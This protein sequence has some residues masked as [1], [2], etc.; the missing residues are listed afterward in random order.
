MKG[1]CIVVEGMT[2]EDRR[3]VS[4]AFY[5]L[6][7]EIYIDI[8]SFPMS[9]KVF[10][11][12]IPE[13]KVHRQLMWQTQKPE[14]G[15]LQHLITYNQLMEEAGM[16]KKKVRPE[17]EVT[18]TTTYGELAKAYAILG[19]VNGHNYGEDLWVSA[20]RILGEMSGYKAYATLEHQDIATRANYNSYQDQWIETIFGSQKTKAQIAVENLRKKAE[21]LLTQ[22]KELE[23]KL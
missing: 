5:K 23:G 4:Q 10:T 8:K 19:R 18:I 3:N 2:T 1:Y 12:V 14:E 20:S 6:G 15:Q 11:N 22:A 21:E 16:T 17:D 13:G 9:A 7:S